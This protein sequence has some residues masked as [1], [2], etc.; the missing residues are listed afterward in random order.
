MGKLCQQSNMINAE[1]SV[2]RA[3]DLKQIQNMRSS[4]KAKQKK[5]QGIPIHKKQRDKLYSVMIMAVEEQSNG[6][7]KLIH[8]VMAWP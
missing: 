4:V 5:E 6:E 3:R 7:E 2:A 8:G 1:S